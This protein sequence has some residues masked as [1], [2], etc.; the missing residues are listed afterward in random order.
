[1]K[2]TFM[3]LG[4]LIGALVIIGLVIMFYS[5]F[6]GK[7]NANQNPSL[8]VATSSN[9]MAQ[10]NQIDNNA[11]SAT[12]TPDVTTLQITTTKQGTGS[13]AKNG[14]MVTVNYTGMFT[15]GKAFDSNI[16]PS[17]GHVQP[18]QFKLGA[19]QVIPGWDQGVLGMKIGEKRHLVI[20]S[21]L[22]YGP[23]GYGPI[24]GGATL[25][26]DVELTAVN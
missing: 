6:S 10:N 16:D 8:E 9:N 3:L 19:G 21:S 15:N 11:P 25:I 12:Q 5:R 22:A 14:D 20:P 4:I 1:M 13:V 2:K 7:N 23:N 26:F 24:P 17:F 18:F